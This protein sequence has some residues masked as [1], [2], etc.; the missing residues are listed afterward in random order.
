MAQPFKTQETERDVLT[1][2]EP[3]PVGREEL[4]EVELRGAWLGD[5]RVERDGV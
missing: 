4:E 5:V 2:Q 1:V 3:L